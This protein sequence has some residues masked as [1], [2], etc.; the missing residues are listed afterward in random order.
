MA[1]FKNPSFQDRQAAAADA[2][3]KALDQL[4]AKTPKDEE[5]LAQER[6]AWTAKQQKL[7]EDRQVKAELAAAAK[8][9]RAAA[10]EAAKAAEELKAARL[11]PATPEE[12]K[13]ARDAR[14]AARKARK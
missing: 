14:Y 2:K 7:A 12:M 3:Q 4:K 11:R 5:V 8:A 9:E 6:A 10:K 1:S 13:A